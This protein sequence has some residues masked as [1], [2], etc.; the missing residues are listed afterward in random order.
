MSGFPFRQKSLFPRAHFQ[1]HAANRALKQRL[2]AAAFPQCGSELVILN[3]FFLCISGAA[4]DPSSILEPS[5]HACLP[6][7]TL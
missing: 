6:T 4:Q 2:A 1:E 5:E 7:A 3:S